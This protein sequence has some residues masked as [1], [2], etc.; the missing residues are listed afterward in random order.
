MM[1]DKHVALEILEHLGGDPFLSATGAYNV[2][3]YHYDLGAR[4]LLPA[5]VAKNKINTVSIMMRDDS[6]Y[7]VEFLEVSAKDRTYRL[8]SAPVAIAGDKLRELFEQ[9]TGLRTSL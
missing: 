2:S 8:V 9:E 4:F 1:T 3:S 7:D 6:L 5:R